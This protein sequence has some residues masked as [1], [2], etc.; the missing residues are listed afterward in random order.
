[1]TH[2][3]NTTCVELSRDGETWTVRIDESG[4]SS[5]RTFEMQSYAESYAEGQRL[6]LGL[7]EYTLAGP[8]LPI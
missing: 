5:S 6:R 8:G 1:M 4:E 7:S 3:P 2:E